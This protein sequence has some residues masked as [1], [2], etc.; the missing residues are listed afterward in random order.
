[1]GKKCIKCGYE[2]QPSDTA[3]DYECPKC[4]IVYAKAEGRRYIPP[5]PSTT[6]GDAARATKACPYCGEEILA[7]AKKCKHCQSDLTVGRGRS[8][9]STAKPNADYGV[10]LLAVPVIA[11]MLLWFWVGNLNLLQNPAEILSIIGIAT[12]A[13]TALIAAMEARDGVK[14]W[15]RETGSQRRGQVLYFALSPDAKCKT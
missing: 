6:T 7:V 13:L 4:G 5:R 2:R 14:S 8:A 3:P 1:M 12:V 11:T 15:K 9:S 10:F